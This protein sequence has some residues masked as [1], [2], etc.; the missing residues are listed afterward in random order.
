MES[1]DCA[2]LIHS[3]GYNWE[4]VDKLYSMLQ[5][6]VSISI[7]LHVY[8]ESTR[9]VP[10]PYIK[11][12]LDEWEFNGL[13]KSWWYKLQLFNAKQH[14]GPL[15]YLDLDTV[16]V[17]NIDWIWQQNTDYFWAIRD[18]KYLWKPTSNTINSSLMWWD[19]VKF[20]W[21][22]ENVVNQQI[23]NILL[24][25]RGDQDYLSDLIP[26]EKVRFFPSD[27][28]KSWRWE[29]VNGGYNFTKKTWKNPGSGTNIDN[30]SVLIFHG[31]PKPHTIDDS[32]IIKYWR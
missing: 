17:D 26:S 12:N 4:Y 8:T 7:K 10:E 22:W 19:T 23:S 1:L 14:S 24:K 5:R 13:C 15:L 32:I 28:I 18:F 6:S 27:K 3:S 31:N 2:C 21:I 16:I 11:H 9:N 29:A 25:Y 20:N 30:T